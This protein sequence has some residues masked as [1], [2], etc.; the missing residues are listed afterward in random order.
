MVSQPRSTHSTAVTLWGPATLCFYEPWKDSLCSLCHS[1]RPP[2]VTPKCSLPFPGCVCGWVL[3]LFHK[4]DLFPNFPQT[5]SAPGPSIASHQKMKTKQ[6]NFY[7]YCFINC[8]F[9]GIRKLA[10]D[11]LI[12]MAIICVTVK[13]YLM[14]AAPY[15]LTV[16]GQ[17]L[18]F[19]CC[20]PLQL[21]S[22]SVLLISFLETILYHRGR[23]DGEEV[24]EANHINLCKQ[25]RHTLDAI[26][27]LITRLNLLTIIEKIIP[28]CF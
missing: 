20:C 7:F 16:V 18:L 9:F 19:L 23:Q 28:F 2:L 11:M 10:T 13:P 17:L 5:A 24:W 3:C 6:K 1:P 27:L 26:S 14:D 21:V 12:I 25:S 15:F 8:Y 4:L 22:P